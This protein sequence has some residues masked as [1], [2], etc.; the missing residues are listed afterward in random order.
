M[1]YD[2]GLMIPSPQ[3]VLTHVR[4]RQGAQVISCSLVFVKA[5]RDRVGL[6]SPAAY[7]IW[8]ETCHWEARREAAYREPLMHFLTKMLP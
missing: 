2:P 8:R 6:C 3:H 5:C 4:G 1:P 7:Q